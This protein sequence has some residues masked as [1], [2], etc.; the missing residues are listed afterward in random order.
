MVLTT[1]AWWH[2]R[3]QRARLSCGRNAMPSVTRSSMKGGPDVEANAPPGHGTGS[4]D[5]ERCGMD[6]GPAW[7][8][9]GESGS[10]RHSRCSPDKPAS[11][12]AALCGKQPAVARHGTIGRAGPSAHRTPLAAAAPPFLPDR[13]LRPKSR[14]RNANFVQVLLT[15]P[16]RRLASLLHARRKAVATPWQASAGGGCARGPA[17]QGARTSTFG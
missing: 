10:A 15:R 2:G 11:Q 7:C 16:S 14:I 3:A 17:G 8:G 9:D 5:R 13:C 1:L 6:P 4:P 12:A